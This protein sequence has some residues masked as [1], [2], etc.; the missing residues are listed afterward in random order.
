M[1]LI[2]GIS[3]CTRTILRCR[4]LSDDGLGTGENGKVVISVVDLRIESVL[5]VCSTL[6][7]SINWYTIRLVYTCWD[8]E[9]LLW[10]SHIMHSYSQFIMRVGKYLQS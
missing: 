6:P 3:T 9:S 2:H 10:L 1:S 8:I 5:T 7:V 4:I